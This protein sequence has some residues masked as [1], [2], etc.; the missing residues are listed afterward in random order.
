MLAFLHIRHR[1]ADDIP[2]TPVFSFEKPLIRQASDENEDLPREIRKGVK[3]LG[4]PNGF[5]HVGDDVTIAVLF[6]RDSAWA[7]EPFFWA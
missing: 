1:L 3:L 6:P 2:S 5:S 7:K 4:A